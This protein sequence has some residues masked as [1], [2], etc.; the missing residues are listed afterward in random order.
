MVSPT[1]AQPP[2][3]TPNV[4]SRKSFADVV[5]SKPGGLLSAKTP[6]RHKGVPAI[7]FPDSDVAILAE[8]HKNTL[9]GYFYRGRP[10]LENIRK[11]FE[12]IG[13]KGSFHLGVMER[14]HIVIRFDAEEDYFRCWNRQSWTIQGYVMRVTKWT[15]DFRPNVESPV[16]PV[17]ISFEGLPLHLQDKRALFDIAGLLGNPLKIDAATANLSRPSVARVCVEIDVTK[18]MPSKVWINCGS[19]GF[20]QPVIYEQRPE[21]CSHCLHLGHSFGNCP[22]KNPDVPKV[23]NLPR[24]KWVEKNKVLSSQ[25]SKQVKFTAA[26]K[27]KAIITDKTICKAS[28]KDERNLS[29]ALIVVDQPASLKPSSSKPSTSVPVPQVTYADWDEVSETEEI[30]HEGRSDVPKP[31]DGV[32]GSHNQA[33]PE[34]GGLDLHEIR[35]LLHKPL[36]GLLQN[37]NVSH[38]KDDFQ[39]KELNK[40]MEFDQVVASKEYASDGESNKD[41]KA[42]HNWEVNWSDIVAKVDAMAARLAMQETSSLSVDC[43]ESGNAPLP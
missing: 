21:Y 31:V 36:P 3:P 32:S 10:S 7:S 25:Q 41:C 26:E 29:K 23:S 38:I 8:R 12:I 15:P 2:T 18:D 33:N 30:F 16:V 14:K 11:A 24:D 17:W 19:L 43:E 27:G 40:I 9:I 35:M 22:K 5:A 39:L 6:S 4:W 28:N 1:A 34:S 13:F 42:L 37:K 20:M